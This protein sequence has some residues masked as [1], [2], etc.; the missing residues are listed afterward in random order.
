VALPRAPTSPKLTD[1]PAYVVAALASGQLTAEIIGDYP[2]M[3]AA[4]IAAAA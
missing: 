2:R 4:R 1:M 3:M